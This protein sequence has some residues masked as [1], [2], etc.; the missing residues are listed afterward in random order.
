MIDFEYGRDLTERGTGPD[1]TPMIDMIFQLLIFFLLTSFFILPAVSVALP[2]SRT[3]Q[4]QPPTALILTVERD[5]RLLLEGRAVGMEELPALLATALVQRED[6][7]VVIQSDRGVPFGRV[8][9][10]MEA[11]RDGG[12]Q[13]ISFLVERIEVERIES[14]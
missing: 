9:Q 7:T 5:G 2:R 13:E 10:V 1:M 14:R 4:V 6:R 3:P 8:V 12:A 11:A